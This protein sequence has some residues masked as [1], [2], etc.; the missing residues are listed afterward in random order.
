MTTLAN[1]AIL[2][3][4]DNRPPMLEKDMYDSWKSRMELYMMNRQHGRM[5][6]ESVENGPLIWP[7]IEEN[8]RGIFPIYDF[9]NVFVSCHQGFCYCKFGMMG[10]IYEKIYRSVHSRYL[11]PFGYFEYPC[12]VVN[13]VP[14]IHAIEGVVLLY[15][16]L[17]VTATKVCVTAAKLKWLSELLLEK[18]ALARVENEW[19]KVV[20]CT[21]LVAAHRKKV[22]MLKPGIPNEHQLK[23]NSIKDAKSLLQAVEKR[24]GG[25]AATKKTQRNLLKQQYENFT[26]SSLEVLDQ[27]FDRLQKLISQLEIHDESISQ[28]D[29]NQN[30]SSTNG[31]VNTAH[32]AT[33]ASTQATVVNSTII[34][35][36]SDAVICAFFASQPNS[37]QLDNED[38][39]QINLDDLEEID[40]SNETIGFD[41]SKVECYSCHKRGHFAREC[42]DPRNQENMNREITRRVVLVETTTSNGLVSCDVLIVDKCK[43]SLGY[44]VVPPLYTKNF[45]PPK[46]DMSFSGLKE[47]TSEPIVTKP[48]VEKSEAKASEAKPKVV[49]KNN[50]DPIN[51]DWVSES[52]E[53]N[54]SQ[55]KIEKK[56]VKL[57]F[58]KIDFV[59]TNQTNKTNRKTAKQV[60]H[61]RQNTHIRRDNQRNWNNIVDPNPRSILYLVKS[62]LPW[63]NPK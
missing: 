47:F 29:V 42:R 44:N 52:K 4:A 63:I 57:S 58:V 18:R 11:D 59:K 10:N 9:V 6:L 56:T 37:S 7:S 27:T 24:F 38:L 5:I 26:T 15:D 20:R 16:D 49:R 8:Y 41:K 35:N 45:M 53:E 51:E 40:F 23:F 50:G 19:F 1:K 31:A 61:N 22:L 33:T 34:D 62:M 32:G 43:T 48:I 36:L 21:I 30:T 25:N 3:G 13:N 17:G 60:E 28:E 39:Q 46:P 2:S 54:V 14:S 12:N 55:T